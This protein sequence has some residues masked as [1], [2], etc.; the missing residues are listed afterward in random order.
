MIVFCFFSVLVYTVFV[1]NVFFTVFRHSSGGLAD[2]VFFT[3]FGSFFYSFCWLGGVLFEA[4][5]KARGPLFYRVFI[6]RL[7]F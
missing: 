1:K 3:V 6:V 2:T 4:V 7:P 5:C